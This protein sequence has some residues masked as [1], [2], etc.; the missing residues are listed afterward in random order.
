MKPPARF[1]SAIRFYKYMQNHID[2]DLSA[3]PDD[4]LIKWQPPVSISEAPKPFTCTLGELRAECF[5]EIGDVK[6][7]TEELY[8]IQLALR[9]Q[10]PTG[11]INVQ[12]IVDLLE[13]FL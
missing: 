13:K 3:A 8:A 9:Y 7:T 1:A 12:H 6:I 11:Q 5:R 2:V 10:Y 4:L